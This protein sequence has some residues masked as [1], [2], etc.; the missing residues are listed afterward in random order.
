MASNGAERPDPPPSVLIVDDDPTSRVLAGAALEGHTG[1]MVEAENGLAALQAMEKQDFDIA[2]LDI[3]MP[4]MDG[5]GVIERARAR[6]AT[7]H[8]PIIVT[9]GRDDVVSIERAFAL[10]ATSFV[11][12]PINWNVFRHQVAYVLAVA[13][14]ERN[15]RKARERAEQVA[16]F[17]EQSIA[18]LAA[19]VEIA[20]ARISFLSGKGPEASLAD[21]FAS[22]EKLQDALSRIRRASELVSGGSAVEFER[23]AAGEVVA[24]TIARI[25]R[26]F[27]SDAAARIE[28][29]GQSGLE[30]HCDRALAAEALYEI[31]A[32]AL[33]ASPPGQPVSL[34]TVA[35]PVD[36]VRFEIADRGPGLPMAPHGRDGS[37][38]AANSGLGLAIAK[39]VVARHGGHF[40]IMSEP[41]RGTEVFLSF[42]APPPQYGKPSVGGISPIFPNELGRTESTAC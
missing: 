32:N 7:R 37:A 18:A 8:L 19:E 11:C 5:F 13:K 10:G 33:A 21:I 27:G 2:I 29:R 3:D 17:R 31:L 25:G 39:A 9:T 38:H 6:P 14:A 20:I 12:K 4:V 35:A 40:G 41:A 28:V 15:A 36:R 1:S 42:P 16:T 22:G 26:A 34:A 30:L 23:A 24:D